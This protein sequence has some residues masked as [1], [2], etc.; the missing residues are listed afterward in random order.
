MKGPIR[1]PARRCLS[2]RDQRDTLTGAAE[3]DLAVPLWSCPRD[4]AGTKF[5]A[6]PRLAVFCCRLSR[7]DCCFSAQFWQSGPRPCTQVASSPAPC[8]GLVF[9]TTSLA[10]S[11]KAGATV[12]VTAKGDLAGERIPLVT[13]ADFDEEVAGNSN[14]FAWPPSSGHRATNAAVPAVAEACLFLSGWLFVA[15]KLPIVRGC[16]LHGLRAPEA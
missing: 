5:C 6:P 3:I 9:S 4:L 12:C 1:S 11:S 8:I 14:F 16:A 7:M 13:V 15:K 2:A 10:G